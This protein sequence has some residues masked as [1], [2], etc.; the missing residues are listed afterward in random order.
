MLIAIVGA[1][2]K[3]KS[4]LFSA[5]TEVEVP[6]ADYAFTT[7]K[8][9]IGVAY[10]TT[11]CAEVGLGVKCMP[12]NSSCLGG[13]RRIPVNVIDVAGL[14]PGAHLGKGMGNQF[15]NDIVNAD[16]LV[17]VV[18]ASGKTD[19]NG[20]KAEGADPS[21][22][23]G[24]ITAELTEWLSDIISKHMSRLEKRADGEVALQ[25][26]LAGFRA[27]TE[28]I[29]QAAD[30]SYLSTSNINW[31][32]DM[33]RK[34][35]FQLLRENK[36]MIVAA[37]KADQAN[38]VAI[39]SLKSKL[40]GIR[41]VE[42][43]AAI[44]LGLSKAS[45]K[46]LIDYISGAKSF[47]TLKEANPEQENALGYMHGYIE[48]H[49]GTGVQELLNEAVFASLSNI[50]VYPVEDETHY[51]DHFGNVLHDAILMKQGA[52]AHDLA[53]R[54]HTDLAAGMK[55]AVDARTKM[56]LQK[57]YVLKHRDVIKIVSGIK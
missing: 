13:T 3:G 22:E 38:E 42:C 54:I 23:V 8:P 39:E 44:E 48:R 29:K 28:Q 14:V 45:D 35:A 21:V 30:R 37:N 26:L 50:V 7:I 46:G 43:S 1:P 51:T 15:L 17:Q 16:V 56:R 19:I 10:A 32:R 31:D 2:N 36:P 53:A 33:T 52:T 25:E 27:S 41:V 6:I 11:E 12:R 4:T 55:Y 34:F 57:E 49:G 24:M 5:M 47:V 18:D 40:E 9:N 20:G